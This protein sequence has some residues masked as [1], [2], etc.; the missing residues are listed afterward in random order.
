MKG[1]WIRFF[2]ATLILGAALVAPA[3]AAGDQKT[4]N[5]ALSADITSLDPMGHNDI[6]SEKVSFL[7]FNRLFK[8]NTNFEAVPDLVAK[9]SNPSPREWLLTIKKGVKFHDGSEMTSADVKFSLDRSKTMAN[10]KHVLA[11]VESVAVVDKYT[12]KVTTKGPF[13]PFLF[14]LAH[15]GASIVSKKYVESGDNWKNP[16]GS[17]PYKFVQWSSG[18]KVVLQ[19]NPNYFDKADMPIA[20]QIVFKI[21]PEATSRT[22]ALQTGDV[23]VVATLDPNDIDKVKADKNLALYTKPSTDIQYLGMNVDKPPFDN[24]LVR[25]AFNYAID[26]DAILIV[27]LNGA[28]EVA[29]SIIPRS[30]MGWKAGPY[31][32]DPAK[33]KELLKQ[34]KYD[35]NQ[36]IKMWVFGD[37]GKKVSEVVQSNLADIGVK[38][39][40]EVFELGA[41]IQATNSGDQQFFKLGWTSNPDPDSMLTPL[42]SKGSIGSQN[43]TRYVNDQ[44]EKLLAAGRVELNLAKR[45]Q[46]YNNISDIVMQDATWVPLY[47]GN[48]T[49]AANAKLQG[50]ELSPQGLWNLEKL[51]Y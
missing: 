20:D 9:W 45:K 23:D 16:I 21:I 19:K 47:T 10:V 8:L 6:Y 4:I 40:I 50:V 26:K 12:V 48:N 24:V 33:A 15:A 14:T 39:D 17:G 27:A 5:V 25:R 36:T 22:I 11:E 32:F 42:F 7:V 41:F 3:F 49:I 1:R 28:G 46:I 29:S 43:R 51:H 34:A 38:V 35:P 37:N 18:D 30:L 13:A 31:T 44:V 2:S